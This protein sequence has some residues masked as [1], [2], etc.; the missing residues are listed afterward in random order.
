MTSRIRRPHHDVT[1]S[2][3]AV[4]TD[5]APFDLEGA[6]AFVTGA[7]SGIGRAIAHE[8]ARRGA[9]VLVTDVDEDRADV[10]AGEI[11]EDGGVAYAQRCDVADDTDFDAAR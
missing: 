2:T 5:L 3:V 1:G 9:R 11:T 10:V 4:V 8:L 7:G 6:A